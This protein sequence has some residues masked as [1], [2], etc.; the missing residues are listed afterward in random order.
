MKSV[1]ALHDLPSPQ[2]LSRVAWRCTHAREH[3]RHTTIPAP[4][5]YTGCRPA[6]PPCRML[7]TV[8]RADYF[9]PAPGRLLSAMHRRA[10]RGAA[11]MAHS[12]PPRGATVL[13]DATFLDQMARRSR[14]AWACMPPGVWSW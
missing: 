10:L 7:H 1:L 12:L 13:P 9:W 11:N 14:L 6:L 3:R 8:S 2:P 4:R 5:R